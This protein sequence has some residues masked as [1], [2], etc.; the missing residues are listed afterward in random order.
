MPRAGRRG[1]SGRAPHRCR[2]GLGGP[3]LGIPVLSSPMM[4]P[5]RRASA[6]T[7]ERPTDKRAAL[8]CEVEHRPAP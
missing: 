2:G 5:R 8:C 3:P 4:S 1:T 6:C 7:Q